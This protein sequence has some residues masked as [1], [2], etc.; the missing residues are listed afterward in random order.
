MTNLEI[1]AFF[2]I[3][4]SGS[5]SAAAKYLY[6]TQPAL[7]RRLK[8]LEEELGYELF[9]RGKGQ[10]SI[11][12]TEKGEA[13]IPTAHKWLAVWQEAKEIGYLN[14]KSLFRV[15][16]V[17]SVS[18]YILPPVLKQFSYL[19]QQVKLSFH[20]YHSLEAY[21]YMDEG[22]LDLAFI[23]DDMHDKK[24]E[25]VPAFQEPMVLA[26]NYSGVYPQRVHPSL[27]DPQKEIRLPW[28]P[29]YDSWHDFWFRP[30]SD[31]RVSLDQ[32]DLLEYFLSLKDL[33]AVVPISVA[34]KIFERDPIR[35]Y[36]LEEG[37]PGRVIYYLQNGRSK[38]PFLDSFLE[39]TNEKLASIPG[40]VSF[41][42]DSKNRSRRGG[43]AE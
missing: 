34:Y 17:G 27:L 25:T 28:Y 41:L 1:E 14:Q 12:L 21:R 42:P 10:R 30:L 18:S 9:D 33:W 24:V 13:F 35:I 19:N 43:K 20:R 15:S 31:Y 22:L 16:S 26:A 5:I 37:P 11:Q 36:E 39:L 4:R 3:L 32:M 38:S 2:A 29:E 8:T 23:S 7:S 6:V 40:I